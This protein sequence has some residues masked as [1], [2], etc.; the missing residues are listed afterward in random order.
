MVGKARPDCV[1]P[2]LARELA[3]LGVIRLYVGVENGSE[4]GGEHL[5]R[6]TQQHHIRGALAACREAGIFVCYNLRT[7]SSITSMPICARSP[8]RRRRP[9][10]TRRARARALSI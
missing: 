2:A 4:A 5:R 7:R 3:E 6:G 8:S 1:T 9:S 10:R